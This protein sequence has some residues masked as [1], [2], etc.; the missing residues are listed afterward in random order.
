MSWRLGSRE[1]E[2]ARS[3][4]HLAHGRWQGLSALRTGCI[5]PPGNTPGT[6]FHYRLS[7]P[8]GHSAVGGVMSVKNYDDPIS[9]N[10]DLMACSTVCQPSVPPCIRTCLLCLVYFF[11]W[12]L[13]GRTASSVHSLNV[14]LFYE[15]SELSPLSLSLS[16]S[17]SHTHTHTLTLT[18]THTHTQTHSH[19]NQF[20]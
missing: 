7:Q 4:R 17:L 18:Y 12:Y 20:I 2:G 13:V 19:T 8:Q 9:R 10:C 5:Y 1:V 3:R 16:L 11:H 15:L 6:H 14:S